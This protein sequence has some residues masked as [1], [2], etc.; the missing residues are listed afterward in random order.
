M[1]AAN[2]IEKFNSFET[3]ASIIKKNRA[4]K[5]KKKIFMSALL[6]F[7]MLAVA[8][9]LQAG[10]LGLLFAV[11]LSCLLSLLFLRVHEVFKKEGAQVGRIFAIRHEY[12]NGTIKG[13]G[14]MPQMHSSIRFTHDLVITLEDAAG[15]LLK[16]EVVCP[17]LYEGA[18]SVG[19]TLLYHPDL[20][21]PANL[22]HL[23][24]CVCMQCGRM[25]DA[26]RDSCLT[27]R[28]P[29]C[30]STTIQEK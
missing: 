22:S 10:P 2:I 4:K 5:A 24:K 8:V 6:L 18:F 25:Q 7:V 9:T 26:S 13:T 14:G 30:N 27:C 15:V 29:L 1:D 19:D 17:S 11:L 23:T 12:Y 20:A 28:A 3:L 21:F 16:R